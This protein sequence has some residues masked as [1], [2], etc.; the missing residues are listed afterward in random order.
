MKTKKVLAVV[1]AVLLAASFL[2]GCGNN[3][4]GAADGGNGGGAVEEVELTFMG[5]E[6]S[7]LETDAVREG[8]RIFEERNPGITVQYTPGLAGAEYNARL[9]AMAASNTL[10]DVMFVGA[11][12]YRTFV[13]RGMLL[14]ITERFDAEFPL[15]DFIQSSREIMSI[16]GQIYGIS[17]CTVS[18]IVYFNKDVFDAAGVP[19]P[20]SDP[21]NAWTID[22][23]RE[24]ARQLTT[25]E[26][27]GVY[28]ME[29]HWLA[30]NAFIL[31]NGG[32][33]YNDDFTQS[34]MYSPEAMEVLEII[35]AIRVE[36]GSAPTQSTLEAV[37]MNPS[38]M[39]Q[40]GRVAMLVDGSWAL[41]ELSQTDLNFGMAPLPHF[42]IVQTT[43]Q[44]HL[45]AISAN[46][47]HPE[48]AWKFLQFLAGMEYQGELVRQGLW[49]PNRISMYDAD[50]VELWYDYDVHGDSIRLM[51][52]YFKNAATDPSALQKSAQASDIVMEELDMFF[53]EGADLR[54]AL[55]N[56][57]RRIDEVIQEVLD[58]R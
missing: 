7:P 12:T 5:W 1:L 25:D 32:R 16:D 46:T 22:E 31:S 4:N 55:Q 36:D 49:M 37:G 51:L 39:L 24:V 14:N 11:D 3:G 29:L 8:I 30:I 43:G 13:N 21:A 53:L 50:Q 56:I 54:T 9:I 38:Q 17:S 34:L 23:F 58:D 28:G 52:D 35:R 40:T 2:I 44:A 6:A 19:H 10:P 20:S 45:H 57:D 27:F 47:D 15:D 18:P 42:G 26:I 33:R 48:A 41:Q